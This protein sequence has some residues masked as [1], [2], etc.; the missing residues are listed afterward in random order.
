MKL[1]K[2]AAVLIFMILIGNV[3][4]FTSGKAISSTPT[5]IWKESKK[6]IMPINW[7]TFISDSE[8]E[9]N[10]NYEK[11]RKFFN[12]CETPR[13]FYD[14]M[15]QYIKE[16]SKTK[17]YSL[18]INEN[19]LNVIVDAVADNNATLYCH[20]QVILLAAGVKATFSHYDE[21]AKK[22]VLNKGCGSF[23]LEIWRSF[24][25][26][27]PLLPYRSHVQLVVD[28][29]N[30]TDTFEIKKVNTDKLEIDTWENEYRAFNKRND[31]LFYIFFPAKLN[32]VIYTTFKTSS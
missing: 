18:P 16:L 9:K 32:S 28:K 22:Y 29:W 11:L 7:T 2:L 3:F 26:H 5:I 27:F 10:N 4:I 6:E 31:C 30:G 21:R 24:D 20:Q 12:D 15:Q 25:L 19:K 13:Q 23:K 8:I 1:I 17:D 14:R